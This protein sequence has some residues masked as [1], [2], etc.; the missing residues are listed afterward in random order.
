MKVMKSLEKNIHKYFRNFQP[1]IFGFIIDHIGAEGSIDFIEPITMSLPNK[2]LKG[3][4]KH[5]TVSFL[6][7]KL[8]FKFDNIDGEW[9]LRLTFE[10]LSNGSKTEDFEIK[11][12][13][14]Y[15]KKTR[16]FKYKIKDKVFKTS[17]VSELEIEIYKSKI[18]CSI[19]INEFDYNQPYT[20]F[21]KKLK[22]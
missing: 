18:K 2:D 20:V 7:K 22:Y 15:A 16:P 12:H 6:T 8:N 4:S 11:N 10:Q 21:D 9:L 3:I 19:T 1:D 17:E 5:E 14:K 13:K